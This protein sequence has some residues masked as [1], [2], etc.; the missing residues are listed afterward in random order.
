MRGYRPFIMQ[1]TESST[2][3]ANT[4]MVP[5]LAL[6]NLKTPKATIK[7]ISAA[8]T[9]IQKM[10]FVGAESFK[11]SSLPLSITKEILTSL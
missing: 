7:P 2:N 10:I 1:A 3:A 6:R 9:A 5:T 4:M 11:L 8:I